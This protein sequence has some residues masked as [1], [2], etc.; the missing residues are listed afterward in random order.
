MAPNPDRHKIV[1]AC[2]YKF[3]MIPL[4]GSCSPLAASCFPMEVRK[5]AR[6]PARALDAS[7]AAAFKTGILHDI[8]TLG[9]HG[10]HGTVKGSGTCSGAGGAVV[11]PRL[12]EEPTMD[13]VCCTL[14]LMDSLAL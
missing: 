5:F 1:F 11:C 9:P 12:P 14:D 7:H 6:A 13:S 3:D 4:A 2:A 8:H 10:Q